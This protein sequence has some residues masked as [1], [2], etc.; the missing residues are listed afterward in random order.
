M[1]LV[2]YSE[3]TIKKGNTKCQNGEGDRVEKTIEV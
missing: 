2:V 1:A 3:T